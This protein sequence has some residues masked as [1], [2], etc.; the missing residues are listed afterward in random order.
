MS[1]L[2]FFKDVTYGEERVAVT[3]MNESESSKDIRIVFKSGQAMKQHSAPYPISVT[4]L[5]GSI[6][7][8][9]DG[10]V[11]TLAAGDMI[12][13]DAS[14]MHS[15]DANE[16]SIVLLQLS[17]NDTIARVESVIK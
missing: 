6:E 9:Y 3:V 10:K 1:V 13:L 14:V 16:D 2:N 7:F 8:G 5:K 15:L 17:K 11:T 4:T 12:K